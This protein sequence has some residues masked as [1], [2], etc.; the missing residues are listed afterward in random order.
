MFGK[1]KETPLYDKDKVVRIVK[2]L[3]THRNSV[4]IEKYLESYDKLVILY[5]GDQVEL[6][7]DTKT[8]TYLDI[9][10]SL[11]KKEYKELHQS[12]ISEV[13]KRKERLTLEKFDKLER[14]LDDS[15]KNPCDDKPEQPIE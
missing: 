8:I 12:F 2:N 6:H 5:R 10:V 9:N 1:K 3:I 14:S 11:S 4:L 7:K 15:P 13:I